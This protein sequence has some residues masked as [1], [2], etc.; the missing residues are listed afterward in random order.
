[1]KF[2]NSLVKFGQFKDAGYGEKYLH[3]PENADDSDDQQIV[4]DEVNKKD[5]EMRLIIG[6]GN[7]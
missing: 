7:I 2:M 3:V 1:M 5:K 4:E 6:I